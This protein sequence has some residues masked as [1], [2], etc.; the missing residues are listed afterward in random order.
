MRSEPDE[1]DVELRTVVAY[2]VHP[3]G[4][5]FIMVSEDDPTDPPDTTPD[6]ST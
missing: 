1:S 3:D 2:D 4:E 5:R 6:D